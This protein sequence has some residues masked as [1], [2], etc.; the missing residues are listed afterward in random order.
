MPRH[1]IHLKCDLIFSFSFYELYVEMCENWWSIARE[2]IKC[3]RIDKIKIKLFLQ[4][5][6]CSMC[7]KL[8][9]FIFLDFII[10]VV[11][12]SEEYIHGILIVRF[13]CILLLFFS[14]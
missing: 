12:I 6:V 11:E 1:D 3:I 4:K 10:V 7:L 2:E 14:Y 5:H 8:S 13:S 9:Q